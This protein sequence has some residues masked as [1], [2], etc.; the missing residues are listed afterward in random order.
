MTFPSTIHLK[1]MRKAFTIIEL[2]IY[3]GLVS[4]LLVVIG[5]ILYSSLEAQLDSQSVS[6]AHQD[7][8]YLL[9]RLGY[10][11]RRATDLTSPATAGQD[12]ASFTLNF[13]G[14]SSVYD[15][16][17][18]RLNVTVGGV[19]SQLSSFDTR[20][21]AFSVTRLSNPGGRPSLAVNFTLESVINPLS[22]NSEIRSYSAVYTLR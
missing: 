19:T 10:D 5:Q 18:S 9:S 14:Q 15:L 13:G 12:A 1:P 16:T 2:L 3:M 8:L 7:G 6:A 20:V 22:Q 17:D 21:T 4:V 11:I